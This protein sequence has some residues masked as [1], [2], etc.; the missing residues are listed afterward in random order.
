MQRLPIPG[1][2]RGDRRVR[3]Q[4]T[5]PAQNRGRNLASEP[6]LVEVQPWAVEHETGDVTGMPRGVQ[7][8]DE[9]ARGVAGEDDLVV[10]CPE[11]GDRRV[12]LLDIYRYIQHPVGTATGSDGAA[13]VTQV[14]SIEREAALLPGFRVM[15]LEEV[16][17]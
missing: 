13:V 1:T 15:G 4:V 2:E 5:D 12:D 6:G 11:Q 14:E 9:P 17:H 3:N 7:A 16:V 8:H 10:T